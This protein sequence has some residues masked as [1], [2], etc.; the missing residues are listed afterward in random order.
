MEEI[1]KVLLSLIE[2]NENEYVEYKVHNQQ[3]TI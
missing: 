2:N 3:M 1:K